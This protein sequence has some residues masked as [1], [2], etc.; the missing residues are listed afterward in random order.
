MYIS[1]FKKIN[2]QSKL[3]SGNFFCRF[4]NATKSKPTGHCPDCHCQDGW[5]AVVQ[6]LA[7]GRQSGGVFHAAFF[8]G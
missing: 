6:P 3:I 5:S 4:G 8:G 2:K 7:G 1:G